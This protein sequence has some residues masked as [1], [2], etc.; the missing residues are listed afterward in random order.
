MHASFSASLW[1]WCPT[2]LLLVLACSPTFNW[3]EVRADSGTQ[4]LSLLLPCKPDRAE[5]M[6]P[7]GGQPTP[8]S[9]IGCEAGSATFA[10]AVA[11][12]GEASQVAA[13]LAQWQTLTLGNMKADAASVSSRP[14]KVAGASGEPAPVLVLAQGQRADGSMVQGQAAYFHSGRKVVQ[15]VMY[16]P[17]I[18]PDA[19]ETFFGSFKLD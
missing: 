14:L 6:V 4:S 13:V 9:M 8:M 15:A 1:R 11:D 19:A 12:L 5:K 2:G 17:K 16:A 18:A 10:V 7:L 3:R